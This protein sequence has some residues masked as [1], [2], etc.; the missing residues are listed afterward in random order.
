M[1]KGSNE[2]NPNFKVQMSNEEYEF[3]IPKP[4]RALWVNNKLFEIWALN[5]G[6]DLNFI[7]LWFITSCKL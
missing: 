4:P 7:H 3:Q 1:T 6:I 5:L 2:L